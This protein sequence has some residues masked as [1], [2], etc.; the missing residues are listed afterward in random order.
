M[1]LYP[2][3]AVTSVSYLS[4]VLF[5]TFRIPLGGETEYYETWLKFAIDVLIELELI[6]TINH[7]WC[8]SLASKTAE[9][10]PACHQVGMGFEAS[11]SRVQTPSAFR[12]GLGYLHFCRLQ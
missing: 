8:F 10:H 7:K 3:D 9:T 6:P 1:W 4:S 2:K 11:L 5:R 12:K